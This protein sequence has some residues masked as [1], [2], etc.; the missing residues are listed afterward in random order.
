MFSFSRLQSF[1]PLS[2]NSNSPQLAVFILAGTKA[3]SST[4]V[5][6]FLPTLSPLS[7]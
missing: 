7:R 6:D 2:S 5:H 1:N 3:V 4:V